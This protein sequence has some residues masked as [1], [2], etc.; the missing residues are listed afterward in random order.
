MSW[1]STAFKEAE[2]GWKQN[3]DDSEDPITGLANATV[4]A[5]TGFGAGLLGGN[6]P[7]TE[8]SSS[9]TGY[10][11]PGSAPPNP[12]TF[13]DITQGAPGAWIRA[14]QGAGTTRTSTFL[15]RGMTASK[16]RAR[17]TASGTTGY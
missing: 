16:I 1:L 3:W 14:K 15:T 9:T 10:N 7:Y 5:A 13:G 12:N 4:G 8:G 11:S 2:A 17:R 6:K